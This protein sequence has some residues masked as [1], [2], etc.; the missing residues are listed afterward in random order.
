MTRN[1]IVSLKFQRRA[2]DRPQVI[3]RRV[4]RHPRRRKLRH[5]NP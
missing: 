1:D 5:A 4:Q 3:N 2:C